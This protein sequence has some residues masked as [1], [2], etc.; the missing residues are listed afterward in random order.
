[1]IGV[2]YVIY[3][4]LTLITLSFLISIDKN[5]WNYLLAKCLL[6]T[7]NIYL[8][9]Y[10]LYQHYF[11]SSRPSYLN[12]TG[13]GILNWL[14]PHLRGTV[15][16]D[17]L[18]GLRVQRFFRKQKL[19]DKDLKK[20]I[21]GDPPI[22]TSI[23][24][25]F[26]MLIHYLLIVLLVFGLA[27]LFKIGKNQSEMGYEAAQEEFHHYSKMTKVQIDKNPKMDL[28]NTTLCFKG[29]CLITDK[30]KNVQL[31]DMKEVTV[32]NNITDDKKAP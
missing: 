18:L 31:Y 3:L 12:R 27:T 24:V 32:L 2:E 10:Y 28:R 11:K 17:Y 4:I 19:T 1:M 21:Y 9:F 13:L 15:R 20:S 23:P 29:F 25:E 22:A 30:N 7:F 26:S 16:L 8:L 6:A 14:K 5:H